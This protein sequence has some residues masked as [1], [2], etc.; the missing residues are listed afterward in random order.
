MS[1]HNKGILFQNLLFHHLKRNRLIWLHRTSLF[2]STGVECSVHS[3][4]SICLCWSRRDLYGKK[5]QV[6]LVKMGRT[7]PP[8]VS[9]LSVLHCRVCISFRDE[10][11]GV[12]WIQMF[13][14]CWSSV[15]LILLPTIPCSISSDDEI[16]VNPQP[17]RF[18]ETQNNVNVRI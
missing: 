3:I 16:F 7:R 17:Q 5:L 14:M 13:K 4:F 6:L 12:M 2:Q 15:Q 9:F 10:I 18:G 8:P 11:S 1:L